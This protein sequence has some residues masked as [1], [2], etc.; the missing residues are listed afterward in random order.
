MGVT[1]RAILADIESASLHD[2]LTQ[3]LG[4]RVAQRV[5]RTPADA[6]D[7]VASLAPAAVVVAPCAPVA[8]SDDETVHRSIVERTRWWCEAARVTGSFV[9]LVS[10]VAVFADALSPPPDEFT[11]ASPSGMPGRAWWAAE[12]IA[13]SVGGAVVRRDPALTEAGSEVATAELVTW[14]LAGRHVGTWHVGAQG[15]DDLHTRTVRGG[16]L[17]GRS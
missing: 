3:M 12:A 1:S 9:V 2:E 17:A 15:L 13:A 11:V 16:P 6:V 8:G 14:V 4:S 5:A 10:D 7:V